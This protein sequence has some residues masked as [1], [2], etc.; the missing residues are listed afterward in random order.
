R[1]LGRR[2]I[3]GRGSLDLLRPR[4]G[5]R[6]LRRGGFLG[7]RVGF[8]VDRA[9]GPVGLLSDRHASLL[10]GT[11]SLGWRGAL[12]PRPAPRK[13]TSGNAPRLPDP[14]PGLEARG[15]ASRGVRADYE[16]ACES[17]T[18]HLR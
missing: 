17:V 14:V 2:G 11:P 3:L 8:T 12:A 13:A 10:R 1:L 7:K 15:R 9:L 6:R 5:L 18:R 16:K 4:G